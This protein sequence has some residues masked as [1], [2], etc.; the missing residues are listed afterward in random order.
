MARRSPRKQAAGRVLVVDS[1]DEG[2]VAVASDDGKEQN[3][4]NISVKKNRA[5]T[6]AAESDDD[7][8]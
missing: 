5:P 7:E 1:D 8:V 3:E 6:P 2:F 4:H